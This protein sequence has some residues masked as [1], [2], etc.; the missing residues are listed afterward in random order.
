MATTGTP[1]L[2]PTTGAELTPVI[3]GA[4]T[5]ADYVPSL[6]SRDASLL[7][8]IG[9]VGENIGTAYTQGESVDY[10]S[11]TLTEALKEKEEK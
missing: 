4:A 3:P 1:Y 10:I 11:R 8:N 2:D 7:S 5:S 6:W 9:K